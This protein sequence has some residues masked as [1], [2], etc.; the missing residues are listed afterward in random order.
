MAFL[1]GQHVNPGQ[2]LLLIGDK[3]R[4]HPLIDIRHPHY[5]KFIKQT[6]RVI[7]ATGNTGLL[8]RHKQAQ[9]KLG[10]AV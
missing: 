1:C 3:L 10:G 2:R 6:H 9:I 7:Y 8:F 5:R 4:Q